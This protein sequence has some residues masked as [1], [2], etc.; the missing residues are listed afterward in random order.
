M[1]HYHSP[2]SSSNV[3][4]LSE[5]QAK[6]LWESPTFGKDSVAAPGADPVAVTVA[7]A[8][9]VAVIAVIVSF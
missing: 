3:S 8:A 6:V 7:V 2:H 9:P 5:T 4:Y 1:G